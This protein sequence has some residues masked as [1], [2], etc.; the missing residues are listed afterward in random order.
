MDFGSRENRKLV[1]NRIIEDKEL[2]AQACA[3]IKAKRGK[4]VL[5]TGCFDLI[6]GGHL[7]GICDAS[8]YGK[9]IVGI[10]SD[11]SVRRLKGSGRPIRD[12]RERAY[13]MA[14]FSAVELVTIFDSDYELIKTVRPNY[15]I[16][17]MTSHIRIWEDKK[18]VSLLE[19]IN[20]EII[21]FGEEKRNSTTRIIKVI[22]EVSV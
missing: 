11:E 7:D 18:R 5:M 16:A 13:L 15:Y 8:E 10:N 12:Q 6:H 4:I 3:D 19:G 22:L 17:S 1:E 2:L 14:G 9:L 21:E 20:A